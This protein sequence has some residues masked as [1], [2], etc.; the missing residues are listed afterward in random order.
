MRRFCALLELVRDGELCLIVV[1]ENQRS[2][3]RASPVLQLL[4]TPCLAEPLGE[5]FEFT[6]HGDEVVNVAPAPLHREGAPSPRVRLR[7]TG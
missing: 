2:R 4:L 5:V 1:P 6:V 3:L 7:R